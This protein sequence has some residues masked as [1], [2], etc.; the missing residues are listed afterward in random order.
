MLRC[1]FLTFVRA[2]CDFPLQG[3]GKGL[4]T[5]LLECLKTMAAEDAAP[6]YLETVGTP[7]QAVHTM[8]RVPT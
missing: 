7:S 3:Q 1:Y 5:T 8:H 4:G 6:I 2:F